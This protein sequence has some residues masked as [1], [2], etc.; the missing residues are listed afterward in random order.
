MTDSRGKPFGSAFWH[1]LARSTFEVRKQQEPGE[2]SISIGIYQRKANDDTLAKPFGLRLNF[3][4]NRAWYETIVVQD[5]PDLVKGMT[6]L[7]Q[8]KALLIRGGMTVDELAAETGAT[9]G[10]IRSKLNRNKSIFVPFPSDGSR[11][12]WG[13]RA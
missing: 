8:L 5:V 7:A 6:I 1:N 9:E 11:K 13:L 3:E 4:P 10:A 2:S 12:K